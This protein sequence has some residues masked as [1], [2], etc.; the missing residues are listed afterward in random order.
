V[1]LSDEAISATPWAT[2]RGALT[3]AS[4]LETG[5]SFP[6]LS[7]CQSAGAYGI[8]SK[9][10]GLVQGQPEQP[11]GLILVELNNLDHTSGRFLFGRWNLEAYACSNVKW[12]RRGNATA[13]CVDDHGSAVF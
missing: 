11:R 2:W 3:T 1:G 10:S 4:K 9:I 6:E 8:P 13:V 5:L 7:A 12:L